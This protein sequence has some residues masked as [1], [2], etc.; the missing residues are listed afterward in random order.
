MAALTP[1]SGVLGDIQ[2]KMV[3]SRNQRLGVLESIEGPVNLESSVAACWLQAAEKP[4]PV[5]S[6]VGSC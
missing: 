2:A 3:D 1:Q 6:A 5:T 4:S